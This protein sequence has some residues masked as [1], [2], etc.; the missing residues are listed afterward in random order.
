MLF[1]RPLRPLRDS[2]PGSAATAVHLELPLRRVCPESQQNPRTVARGPPPSTTLTS[3]RG[4]GADHTVPGAAGRAKLSPRPPPPSQAPQRPPPR[5]GT[6]RPSVP[7]LPAAPKPRPSPG[8]CPPSRAGA[9]PLHLIIPLGRRHLA[10][11]TQW[12]LVRESISRRTD[13]SA[14]QSTL[15]FLSGAFNLEGRWWRL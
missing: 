12:M 11:D 1:L 2:S 8:G 10:E 7:L 5:R 3:R 13:R 14:T 4:D 6:R 15:Y 9:C